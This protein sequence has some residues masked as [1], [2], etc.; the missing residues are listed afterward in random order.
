MKKK[1]TLS[2]NRKILLLICFLIY[3]FA[4]FAK[5]SY[6]A[7]TISVIDAYGVSKSQAGLVSTLF[8]ISYGATQIIHGIFCKYY[9]RRVVVSTALLVSSVINILFFFKIPFVL[10]NILWCLNGCVQSLLWPCVILTLSKNFDSENMSKAILVMAT[11][12]GAGSFLAYGFSA[13]FVE[14]LSYNF[15]FLLSGVCLLSICILWFL[16]FPFACKDELSAKVVKV[17]KEKQKPVEKT[18][19][20]SFNALKKFFIIELV[21]LSVYAILNSFIKDGLNTWV[22]S[23]LKE[24]YNLSESL[25]IFFTVF[26]FVVGIFGSTVATGL[27]KKIRDFSILSVFFFVFIAILVGGVILLFKTSLWIIVVV[28]FCLISLLNHAITSVI[29]SMAP[30]YLSKKIDAGFL[31][32]FMNGICYVGSALSSFGL[33]GVAENYGWNAVLIL[34]LACS[35]VPI[36]IE[37]VYFLFCGKKSKELSDIN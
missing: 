34:L 22:P 37:L 19:D 26:L 8:F 28:A 18:K 23:I 7:N 20:G 10:V 15:T 3:T 24:N 6:T 25:S 35:V 21:V 12:V 5:Y 9:N 33:G 29:T 32:G 31:S 4:Y 36:V 14:I 1:S 27:Y 13:L 17:E 11:T 16:F 30:L 2:F